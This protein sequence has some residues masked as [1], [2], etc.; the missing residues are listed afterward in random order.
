MLF[1]SKSLEAQQQGMYVIQ[2]KWNKDY[3]DRYER[4]NKFVV[5]I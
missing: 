2:F 1:V 5:V 4:D 3:N